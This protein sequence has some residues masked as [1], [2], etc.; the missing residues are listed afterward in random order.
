MGMI[1]TEQQRWGRQQQALRGGCRESVCK[2]IIEVMVQMKK[3]MFN[4]VPLK[5]QDVVHMLA[6]AL[7]V[8]GI[9]KAIWKGRDGICPIKIHML[10]PL[11]NGTE[12]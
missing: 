11:D 8:I 12:R 9:E 6:V 3:N 2:V 10:K 5:I 4:K 7:Q 1:K